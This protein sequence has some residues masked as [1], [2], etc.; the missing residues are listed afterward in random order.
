VEPLHQDLEKCIILVSMYQAQPSQPSHLVFHPSHPSEM[1][2]Q[3]SEPASQSLPTFTKPS[4]TFTTLQPRQNSLQ[5]PEEFGN[6]EM[7]S[8]IPI[9]I[10][11]YNSRITQAQEDRP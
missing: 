3:P 10:P 11:N 1:H 7:A 6:L 9:E 4:L 8:R 2:N 5:F